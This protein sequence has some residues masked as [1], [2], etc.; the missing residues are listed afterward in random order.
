MSETTVTDLAAL[1]LHLNRPEPALI[2][3]QCRYALQTSGDA[4][5]KHLWERHS[6]PTSARLGLTSLV[7]SLRLPDPNTIETRLDG[8]APHPH[9]VAQRGVICRHCKF[10]SIN[11]ELVRK[12]LAKE[13]GLRGQKGG[14]VRDHF[15]DSV[16]LQSWTQNGPRVYWTIQAPEDNGEA[17][18]VDCNGTPKR[19]QRVE[20]MHREERE[21]I[22]REAQD[23][24]PAEVG[25]D[26]LS[27]TSNWMRRTDWANRYQ[28][29][30][31][32]LLRRLALAP[33]VDGAPFA[34]G[35][36]NGQLLTSPRS[37]DI[38]SDSWQERFSMTPP[39]PAGI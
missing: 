8:S 32:P 33:S 24:Q 23:R 39:P 5:T 15:D 18:P 20:A 2:C 3:L 4:V 12:H 16:W 1:G 22:A 35:E 27:L 26:D 25:V 10:R 9:L 37:D 29:A 17:N 38:D 13:H 6:I 36:A 21:R 14:A 19:R 7:R 11:A 28:W 31:R 34:I 30:N